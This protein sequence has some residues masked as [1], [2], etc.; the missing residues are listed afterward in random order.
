MHA[1]TWPTIAPL[2]FTELRNATANLFASGQAVEV[3][4]TD[5][6]DTQANSVYQDD[7][8]HYTAL[9]NQ[10]VADAIQPA[11]DHPACSGS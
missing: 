4:V 8:V 5:A 3:D 7:G 6:F 1:P 9:G 11:L 2:E 10:L